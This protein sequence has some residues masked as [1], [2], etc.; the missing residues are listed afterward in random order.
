MNLILHCDWLPELARDYALRPAGE[1]FPE[2]E[3]GWVSLA[4]VWNGSIW[5][6]NAQCR[7][8]SQQGDQTRETFCANSVAICCVEMLRSFR[9]DFTC[10]VLVL[11]TS[12]S[13][14]SRL[15]FLCSG[16]LLLL[17]PP[18]FLNPTSP[19]VIF[20]ARVSVGRSFLLLYTHSSDFSTSS[21]SSSRS[22]LI[23][24]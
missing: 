10:D 17:L 7:Y 13:C 12:R 21:L 8:I 1:F 5:A 14:C 2:A 6:N 22:D 19:G 11:T 23:C 18:S 9:R 20:L 3:T 15:S 4:Q 24:L 16:S